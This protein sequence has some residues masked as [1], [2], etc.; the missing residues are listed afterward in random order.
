MNKPVQI[1]LVLSFLILWC[2]CS[3][4]KDLETFGGFYCTSYVDHI[5]SRSFEP[6][7]TYQSPDLI[8]VEARLVHW[9]TG[10][11][12]EDLGNRLIVISKLALAEQIE[13]NHS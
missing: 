6:I 8:C 13:K 1:L 4:R 7:K 11:K 5:G 9:K 10:Y 2:G 3:I 12:R